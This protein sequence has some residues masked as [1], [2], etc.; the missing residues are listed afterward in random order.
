MSSNAILIL[1]WLVAAPIQLP[2]PPTATSTNLA[3][4]A[5]QLGPGDVIEVTAFNGNEA[6][7]RSLTVAV[8][9]TVM[10]PFTVNKLIAVSGLTS[11]QVRD[12]ILNEMRVNFRDPKVQVVQTR[13]ESKKAHLA[14]EVFHPGSYPI[15]GETTLLDLIIGSGGFPAVANLASVQIIRTVSNQNLNVNLL[16]ALLGINRSS[17]V[18]LEPGDII[19]VPSIQAVSNKVFVLVDGRSAQLLQTPERVTLLE[20]L[21]RTNSVGPGVKLNEVYVVGLDSKTGETHVKAIKFNEM[22]PTRG[23]DLSLNVPLENGDIVF[24]PKSGLAKLNEVLT[25]INPLVSFIR[26]TAYLGQLLKRNNP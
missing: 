23:A 12:I 10:V 21:A 6:E 25:A 2:A 18:R 15:T 22:F 19:Y 26:D 8:D 20:A 17:N 1:L 13:I 9:G 24:I 4:A 3:P 11:I 5:F 16:D 14:G 7:T